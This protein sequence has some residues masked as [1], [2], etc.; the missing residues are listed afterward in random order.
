V[1]PKKL[2]KTHGE[3]HARRRLVDAR[4]PA[5]VQVDCDRRCDARRCRAVQVPNVLALGVHSRK[6]L[7]RVGCALSEAL[8]DVRQ[9]SAAGRRS[10]IGRRPQSTVAIP[11]RL[12][13]PAGNSLTSV[14]PASQK[15]L[16]GN[17]RS[18]SAARTPWA[19][20]SLHGARDRGL[21]A[22]V[23]SAQRVRCQV[24]RRRPPSV[25]AP[26]LRFAAATA[27]S[28]PTLKPETVTSAGEPPAAGRR[29][30]MEDTD[31]RSRMETQMLDRQPSY[32]EFLMN[33]RGLRG[34]PFAQG[35][36]SCQRLPL[37]F[38]LRESLHGRPPMPPRPY[39]VAAPAGRAD[40]LSSST[41]RSSP[42]WE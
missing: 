18:C 6:Q 30:I 23:S 37:R 14:A 28:P 4:Q 32:F 2:A 36:A 38:A 15:H 5:V 24:R 41:S 42:H 39:A 35:R 22:G 40:V 20:A 13:R 27:P 21:P 7:E 26:W 25:R 17:P 33:N 29:H 3:V 16:A 8:A 10:E 12:T 34:V 11:T 31:R 9:R 19:V 1:S